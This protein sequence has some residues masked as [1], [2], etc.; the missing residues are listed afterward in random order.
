MLLSNIAKEGNRVTVFIDGKATIGVV[1]DK[2]HGRK[3]LIMTPSGSEIWTDER[4]L[5]TCSDRYE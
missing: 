5:R 2:R 4:K 1:L 3:V